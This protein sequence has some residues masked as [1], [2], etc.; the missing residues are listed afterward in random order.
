MTASTP[1]GPSES[2]I[3]Q[4]AA[5][6]AG[7]LTQT[8]TLLGTPMYVAREFSTGPKHAEPSPMLF[9]LGVV[10]CELLIGKVPVDG[11]PVRLAMRG[12]RQ[13]VPALRTLPPSLDA[14]LAGVPTRSLS[15]TPSERSSTAEV[16]A[17]LEQAAH[18]PLG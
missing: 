15:I 14:L 1:L 3:L 10:T 5:L 7:N 9:S 6:A 13:V 16:A 2:L 12:V 11:P 4:N 8:G 17:E 18:S